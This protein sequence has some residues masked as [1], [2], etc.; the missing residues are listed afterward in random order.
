MKKY[1]SIQELKELKNQIEAAQAQINFPDKKPGWFE[2]ASTEADRQNAIYQSKLPETIEVSPLL[3]SYLAQDNA[4]HLRRVE[5]LDKHTHQGREFLKL[6]G[7]MNLAI[8]NPLSLVGAAGALKRLGEISDQYSEL[9][10]DRGAIAGRVLTNYLLTNDPDG[11]YIL[12]RSGF[13]VFQFSVGATVQQTETGVDKDLD[14]NK[15]PPLP[16]AI[17]LDP[18]ARGI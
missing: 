15:L 11:K 7:Y 10:L 5:R 4:R 12:K 3:A 6:L 1:E 18:P 2:S 13:K 16:S 14:L 17:S 8:F 9:M